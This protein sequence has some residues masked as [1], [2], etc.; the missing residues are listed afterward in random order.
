MTLWRRASDTVGGVQCSRQEEGQKVCRQED[1]RNDAAEESKRRGRRESIAGQPAQGVQV[2]ASS[3]RACWRRAH[4]TLQI[5]AQHVVGT[6]PSCCRSTGTAP[7]FC[8]SLQILQAAEQ[9]AGCRYWPPTSPMTAIRLM[10]P[11]KCC[12]TWPSS[13]S[14]LDPWLRTPP[15]M[16]WLDMLLPWSPASVVVAEC[17]CC[18]RSSRGSGSDGA[19]ASTATASRAAGA[20]A[21]LAAPA[22]DA[23]AVPVAAR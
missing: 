15:C 20:A 6:S 7:F 16:R 14:Q 4:T 19:A 17:A 10:P 23:D 12:S 21:V 2:L 13:P 22:A 9:G 11:S 18:R 1:G 5:Q 3:V 8:T